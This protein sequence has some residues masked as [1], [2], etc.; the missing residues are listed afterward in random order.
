MFGTSDPAQGRLSVEQLQTYWREIATSPAGSIFRA[1]HLFEMPPWDEICSQLAWEFHLPNDGYFPRNEFGFHGVYR[2]VALATDRDLEHPVILNRAVGR[3]V[4]GTLYIGESGDLGRRLNEARRSGWGSR[5]E[6]SHGAIEML[7]DI[8][9]LNY[10]P[11]RIGIA[12]LFTESPD[13]RGIE[14]DLIR[15]YMNTFGDTPPLNYRL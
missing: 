3:D 11:H 7:K 10:L 15:S 2:L 8:R 9:S 4:S 14:R 13:T 12:V 1:L 5:N 6:R